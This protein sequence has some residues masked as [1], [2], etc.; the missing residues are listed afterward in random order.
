MRNCRSSSNTCIINMGIYCVNKSRYVEGEW[1]EGEESENK[2]KIME[3]FQKGCVDMKGC[4][5]LK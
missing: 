3:I 5:K 4:I 1:L 2:V